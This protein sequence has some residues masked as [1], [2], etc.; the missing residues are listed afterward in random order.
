[1]DAMSD[2]CR[3]AVEC[4]A[5]NV[6]RAQE[7]FRSRESTAALGDDLP[8]LRRTLVGRKYGRSPTLTEA[9]WDHFLAL[10]DPAELFWLVALAS[11]DVSMVPLCDV[12]R[13]LFENHPLRR[14]AMDAGLDAARMERVGEEIRRAVAGKRARR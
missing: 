14:W 3:S 2:A 6:R 13:A 5:W 10:E 12:R 8:A 11:L 9:A 1:P 7:E 4:L